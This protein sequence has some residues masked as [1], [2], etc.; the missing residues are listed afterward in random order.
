MVTVGRVKLASVAALVLL[1]AAGA[2]VHLAQRTDAGVAEVAGT[3]STHLAA[4]CVAAFLSFAAFPAT[5]RSDLAR[6]VAMALLLLEVGDRLM[7]GA[8]RWAD[9]AADV[10]A[11]CLER[12]RG[13][14]RN[15]PETPFSIAYPGDR[16]RRLGSTLLQPRRR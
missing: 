8:W 6:T 3:W 13:L 12:L 7:F 11:S 10:A 5:R 4:S 14:M 2:Y 16:R 15:A 9:V 1:V